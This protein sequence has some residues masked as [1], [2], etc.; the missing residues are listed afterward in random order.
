MDKSESL[1]PL[2]EAGI[3]KRPFL[4]TIVQSMALTYFLIL[5]F[6]FLAGVIFSEKVAR[7]ISP[8]V[9]DQWQYPVFFRW[10]APAGAALYFMAVAGI[11]LFML[12]S[13]GGF[14][15]FFLAALV[16]FTLDIM[17]LN[18]DWLRY[19]IHSGFIFILGVAHFSKRCY[20]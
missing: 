14:Y 15:L 10:I 13:K 9:S 19:L 18:F 2:K 3:K 4:C 17:F 16:I 6:L 5:A 1:I 11:I 8:Y 20:F 7:A 12:K